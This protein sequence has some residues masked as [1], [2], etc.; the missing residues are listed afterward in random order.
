MHAMT[1][2]LTASHPAACT[3]LQPTLS[4]KRKTW[5][6]GTAVGLL[7]AFL[8]MFVFG[9]PVKAA[10]ATDFAGSYFEILSAT[11]KT[12]HFSILSAGQ[13]TRLDLHCSVQVTVRNRTI[14]NLD[15]KSLT[16]A[17]T[18]QLDACS[19]S[20][21]ADENSRNAAFHACWD[22]K[23]PIYDLVWPNFTLAPAFEISPYCEPFDDVCAEKLHFCYNAADCASVLFKSSG[24]TRVSELWSDV[25]GCFYSD[26]WDRM[27]EC[28]DD[29]LW[30][31][32][33]THVPRSNAYRTMDFVRPNLRGFILLD[34]SDNISDVL[35]ADSAARTNAKLLDQY[36]ADW[37]RRT[38]RSIF[39]PMSE[40]E[41]AGPVF[42]PLGSHLT[43]GFTSYL[44]SA[45]AESIEVCNTVFGCLNAEVDSDMFR[46]YMRN[47]HI[48][49]EDSHV[50][51]CMDRLGWNVDSTPAVKFDNPILALCDE[52]IRTAAKYCPDKNT[53]ILR[54]LVLLWDM[55]LFRNLVDD[56]LAVTVRL[57]VE[58]ARDRTPECL[59]AAGFKEH[60]FVIADHASSSPWAETGA[61]RTKDVCD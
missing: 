7:A 1:E 31:W 49:I 17:W 58:E 60:N 53:G 14:P 52:R 44:E 35:D 23:F 24:W 26:D 29:A 32:L 46:S 61:L 59:C 5:L 40:V 8:L 37:E 9:S 13:C 39:R 43:V 42:R 15:K 45:A 25:D 3:S 19:V 30:L 18:D 33:N 21:T 50:L 10:S 48:V 4:R 54:E 12:A 22:D 51:N 27:W 28:A 11:E 56:Q 36:I 20:A 55:G 2:S 34:Y 47:F 16:A 57:F 41:N 38:P 6:N